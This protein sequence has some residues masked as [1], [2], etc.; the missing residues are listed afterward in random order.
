MPLPILAPI[1]GGLIGTAAAP[2]IGMSTALAA[3]LGSFVG[4]L[5]AGQNPGQAALGGIMGALVPGIAGAAGKG[6]Q[7][8][9]SAGAQA[10]P[11]MAAGEIA[12][13]TIAS[14]AAPA[15]TQQALTEAT[16]KAIDPG[17]AIELASTLISGGQEEQRQA[18]PPGPMRMRLG[19]GQA[20]SSADAMSNFASAPVSNFASA[21]VAIEPVLPPT[22]V[23]RIPLQPVSAGVGSLA[24][25]ELER[26]GLNT[27]P[28]L[29]DR[30]ET[31]R[32]AVREF[33][34]GGLIRGPGTGTSDDIDGMI[35]QSGRPVE[36]IK[37][38]NG[39]VILSKKDLAAA[40]PDGDADRAAEL[41]GNAPNG[42]RAKKAAQMLMGMPEFRGV[43]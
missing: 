39:E 32:M 12:K 22:G 37:V 36:H 43:G 15:A 16:K 1:I 42:T 31:Y 23:Q 38:S 41:I 4:G 3:G 28:N 14:S 26:R 18:P 27:L 30:E 17:K 24:V 13:Q 35:Y 25:G 8:A 7:A 29:S 19:E 5:A 10:A 9:A 34:R 33:A 40:D 2:A 11:Q 21:P 6:A 20:P